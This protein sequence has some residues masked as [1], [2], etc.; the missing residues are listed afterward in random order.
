MPGRLL[1]RS[2]M[3]IFL[4]LENRPYRTCMCNWKSLYDDSRLRQRTTWQH[5]TTR[6]HGSPWSISGKKKGGK[7]GHMIGVA[8]MR[9]V[10]SASGQ[11][12]WAPSSQSWLVNWS[13]FL[14]FIVITSASYICIHTPTSIHSMCFDHLLLLLPFQIIYHFNFSRY[15]NFLLFT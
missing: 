13:C 2:W 5:N 7:K 8:Q 14:F 3:F 9:S 11:T 1:H 15:I 4:P 10:C 12:R 6:G